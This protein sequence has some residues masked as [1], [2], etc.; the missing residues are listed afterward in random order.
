[1]GIEGRESHKVNG[2]FHTRMQETTGL[3]TSCLNG[4]VELSRASLKEGL[5]QYLKEVIQLLADDSQVSVSMLYI[6]YL[7][8]AT[9]LLCH[10]LSLLCFSLKGFVLPLID[11]SQNQFSITN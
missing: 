1:M 6:S 3:C 4:V 10:W 9:L 2:S 7:C 11:A 5:H 8:S